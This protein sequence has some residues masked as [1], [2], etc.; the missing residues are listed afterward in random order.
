M[1]LCLRSTNYRPVSNVLTISINFVLHFKVIKVAW[2]DP[3]VTVITQGSAH[4]T[5]RTTKRTLPH[6]GS[7]WPAGLIQQS[8]IGIT[9][10]IKNCALSKM[11]DEKQ[12]K[13][14]KPSSTIWLWTLMQLRLSSLWCYLLE[15]LNQG[16]FIGRTKLDKMTLMCPNSV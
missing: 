5:L 10:N 7:V 3:W 15:K 1:P 6:F 9:T 16:Y 11:W 13:I 12:F 14:L 4:T 8:G 2:V